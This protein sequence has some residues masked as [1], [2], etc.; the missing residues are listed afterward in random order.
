V[1]VLEGEDPGAQA[2][3]LRPLNDRE[4]MIGGAAGNIEHGEL[5]ELMPCDLPG[6][7]AQQK[8]PRAEPSVDP[9]QIQQALPRVCVGQVAA[10]EQFRA[11][12][13]A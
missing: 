13:P 5:I 4:R 8:S 11:E 9:P 2:A 12:N 10:V 7:S 3:A 1:L 6:E